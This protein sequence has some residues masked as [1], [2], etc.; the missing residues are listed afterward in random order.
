VLRTRAR[1]AAGLCRGAFPEADGTLAWDST[2]L[3]IA[4]IEGGG[5]RG[6]GYTFSD[7]AVV[8]VITGK[9]AEAI[10]GRDAF[11]IPGAHR[12]MLAAIRNLGRSGLV[13]NAIS[14]VDAAL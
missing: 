6:P 8:G 13:A 10:R 5:Q 3:V 2:T 12:A 14:A 1:T 4:E 9:L 11:A 7:S